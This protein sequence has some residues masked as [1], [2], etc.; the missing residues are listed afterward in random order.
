MLASSHWFPHC[1]TNQKTR[2][3]YSKTRQVEASGNTPPLTGQNETKTISNPRRWWIQIVSLVLLKIQELKL[4]HIPF[5]S[6]FWW[7]TPG[8]SSC[9]VTRLMSI[10]GIAADGSCW[11]YMWYLTW[12]NKANHYKVVYSNLLPTFFNPD[13]LR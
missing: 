13:E 10:W 1:F 7:Q 12:A 8:S 11:L 2:H 3:S 5:N 6:H 9:R 4:Y